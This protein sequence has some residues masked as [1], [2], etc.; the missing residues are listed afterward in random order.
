MR[1]KRLVPVLVAGIAVLVAFVDPAAAS[2]GY[3]SATEELIRNLNSQ[4]VAAAITI[5]LLV[6]GILVYTVW[7]FRNADEAK[8][9]K[10][11]RRLE[12]TWTVATA[13][14]L[15]FVGVSAYGAMGTP[16]LLSSGDDVQAAMANEDSA[17]V[18][19]EGVQ[20]YWNY[21]Y[22]GS[23]VSMSSGA[24]N[25][26]VVGNQ[27]LVL[28]ADTEVT[29]QTESNDVIHAFHAPELGLKMDALPGQQNHLVTNDLDEGTYQ[30]YCAEFC[31]AGHSKMLSKIHVV[32]RD[33]YD[34]YINDP[35]NVS[36]GA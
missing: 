13:V 4:L 27:P 25:D 8:P 23:N 22:A 2:S 12:I 26:T 36:V 18:T 21:D 14:V 9:T 16:Y 19:V 30:L 34:A 29:I 11:N 1:G 15:L 35:E 7:K 6:E 28:P 24:G 10:E 33:T 32:D 3:Q 20:W 5:T 31:G 17:T